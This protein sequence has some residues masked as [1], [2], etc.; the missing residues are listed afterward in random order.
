MTPFSATA[1]MSMMAGRPS[2]H[3]DVILRY[4]VI[5]GLAAGRSPESIITARLALH[6]AC[7]M[8]GRLVV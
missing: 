5:P 7:P 8:A 3:V 6:H 1:A 4:S 2:V